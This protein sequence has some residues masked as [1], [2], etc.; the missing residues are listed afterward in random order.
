M[1]IVFEKPSLWQRLW[2]LLRGFDL[3]LLAA[4]L[5][6]AGMGLTAMYSSGFDHGTRFADHGRNMLIAAGIM[7]VVAQ[8]PPQR[9]MNLAVP[10]YTL[11]VALLVAV[12][13]F[14]VT[15]KGATRWINV[16]V[17]IQ[18]SELLK[19]A[20]PLMLAWWFHRREG[21]TRPL[22]FLVAFALLAVPVGLIMKQPDL[23][24]ALLVMAA[25]LAVI[26]F[27][28]LPWKLVLPPVVLGLAA[29]VLIVMYEPTLCA[30]D[31]DWRV[32][33]EYQR[34]RICTLLDPTRDPLG[35]GF[36]ILQGMIAIGSGGL[37][38]KGFMQGTQTHLEFIPERTTDFIFAA[39]SEEFGLAG[40]L[41]LIVGFVFLIFRG[42]MIAADAPTLFARLLA[43]ALTTIFFTYAFVN[44]GMVSGI[45]PV[46]GV[47]LP[48]ISYGGT[49]MVTL[50]LALGMLM[51][52]AKSKRMLMQS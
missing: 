38:G 20:M 13:L 42:L 35:K 47:P 1:A 16:G 44:M 12:A 28:G 46:V 50:G 5:V 41:A 7:F 32:L 25:G 37:W 4:V 31:V 45:L 6:L 34:Q 29:V 21:Q 52:I 22:D 23:G 18:P 15:K 39:F 8:I 17:V 14:G 3:L 26:F 36:H 40:N 11:G 49:A 10:L 51:S 19:I 9:L 33:H 43:A 2:P 27:A 30:D 48:F 24:T